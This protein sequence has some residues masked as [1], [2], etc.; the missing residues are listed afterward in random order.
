MLRS[1]NYAGP[2]MKFWNSGARVET[3]LF[4]WSRRESNLH[5]PLRRGSFY[6]LNYRTTFKYYHAFTLLRCTTFLTKNDDLP[7]VLR[8]RTWLHLELT[9]GRDAGLTTG[10]RRA[11]EVAV[12]RFEEDDDARV[13]GF[14]ERRDFLRVVSC[15]NEDIDIAKFLDVCI[16][17]IEDRGIDECHADPV[18]DGREA[19]LLTLFLTNRAHRD[20]LEIIFT[21]PAHE[22]L[23]LEGFFGV[24]LECP[25]VFTYFLW[26]DIECCSG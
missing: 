11:G 1:S 21:R 19:D 25:D 17:P 4:W 12:S 7:A 13:D 6:P 14:D 15:E 2:P 8:E 20:A 22:F 3:T 16:R 9:D 5:L 24:T 26:E 10:L 18:G 23:I